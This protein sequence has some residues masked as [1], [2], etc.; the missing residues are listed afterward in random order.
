MKQFR[1]DQ[2]ER[3]HLALVDPANTG[4]FK[5]NKDLADAMLAQNIERLANLQERLFAHGQW[6]LLVVLQGMDTAG[7]DGVIKHVMR[8]LNPQGCSIHA[9]KTPT[10][11]ELAY[12]FLRPAAIHLPARGTIGIFNRS[13]YE[14]VVV[15]RV[16]PE[17][18]MRQKLPASLAGK[19]IWNERFEDIRAFELHLARNG[20]VPLKF[21]LYISKEEQRR[22]LLARLDD[23]AKR[24][25]FSMADVVERKF[26]DGYMAAYED[27]IRATSTR[28]APWYVVPAD[29]KWFARWIVGRAILEAL[30]GLH[31][32]YPKI[33]GAALEELQKLRAMLEAE[34]G[35]DRTLAKKQIPSRKADRNMSA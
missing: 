12:D 27:M 9:F 34:K 24:W 22:R 20:I 29:H 10:M 4:G 5:V 32:D 31:L 21:F 3:F 15:V 23:P 8:G 13:H 26:W 2:P 1:I 17:M 14:E 25:K 7:K 30:E 18:L 28:Q 6:A 11:E 19:N 35:D 16:H 33:E